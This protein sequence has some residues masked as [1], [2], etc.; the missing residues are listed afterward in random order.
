MWLLSLLLVVLVGGPQWAGR[1]LGA[2][3]YL[4]KARILPLVILPALVLMVQAGAG[5]P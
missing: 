2:P 4:Q 1:Q 5:R 3:W